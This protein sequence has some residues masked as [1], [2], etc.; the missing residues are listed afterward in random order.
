MTLPLPKRERRRR[1]RG[2]ADAAARMDTSCIQVALNIKV[3]NAQ[4]SFLAL[5]FHNQIEVLLLFPSSL[6]LH[7][8]GLSDRSSDCRATALLTKSSED[9]IYRHAILETNALRLSENV[10]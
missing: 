3:A 7:S 5:S 9:I 4:P 6:L 2:K 1:S 8:R 10:L